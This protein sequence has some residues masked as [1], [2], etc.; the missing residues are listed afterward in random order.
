VNETDRHDYDTALK[1]S[2]KLAER[3]SGIENALVLLK[4]LP[5]GSTIES[6]AEGL[7][8]RWQ[9]G[10]DR[11]GKGILYVHTEEENL[12][13][14]EV[15]YALEGIFP[16]VLCH[17]LEEAAR[18]YMLSE[19]PQDFVTE[20][21]ITMNIE[22]AE[23][24]KAERP[25]AHLD[26]A[27]SASVSR[28]LS[29]GAGAAASGYRRTLGDY[30]K[31]VR[32]LPLEDAAA[33]RPSRDPAES[34]RQYL[35]S[36]EHGLGDPRL[37]LLT[38]GSQVFRLVVP[39]NPAQQRRVLDYYERGAP[40]Q[41]YLRGDLGV[42]LFRAGVPNLPIV[43][44]RSRDGLWYVDEAKSWTWFHR[45]EDGTDP[46]PKYD[47]M[48]LL[49]ALKE[50]HYPTADRVIYT[51]RVATPAPPS[52]PFSLDAAVA[53]LA[54]KMRTEPT[55]AEWPARLGEIYLFETDW[56]SK[57]IDCFETA[58]HLDPDRLEHRWRLYDLYINHSEVEKALAELHFLAEKLPGDAE[59][60][61]WLK[62]YTDTYS[63]APGEFPEE[64][65]RGKTSP[66]LPSS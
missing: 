5:P 64:P 27:P 24:S 17:R 7:F 60:Q 28:F 58:A 36:L 37:P 52:Y 8:Q 14:I 22:A 2:L 6:A 3:R 9:I 30:L 26:L 59:V 54:D 49:F 16:D 25:D 4:K 42:A 35:A 13:K 62:F 15:S 1:T 33:F 20:L 29:G 19:I 47:D 43:L 51:R 18:T 41:L 46:F 32:E 38:E 23:A 12:F 44:R 55:N 56:I 31:A 53:A 63:T 40:H 45:W 39:R 34:V 21:M 48:P 57:T 65:K 11:S 10:R 66:S 50:A 61:Y